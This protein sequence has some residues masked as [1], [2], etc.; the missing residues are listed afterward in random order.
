MTNNQLLVEVRNLQGQ[1]SQAEEKAIKLQR[2]LTRPGLTAIDR[3]I[4]D[5]DLTEAQEE[6]ASLQ[7]QLE[8]KLHEVELL[9]IRAPASGHIVNWQLRQNLLRR[10]VQ[11]GQNLMTL[12]A[13]DTPWQIEL[14]IPERRVAHVLEA[15]R[16]S[17]EPLKV[18][19]T[20]ASHPG[21]EFIG[22]LIELDN[23]LDVRGDEGNAVLARVEFDEQQLSSDL[24]RS[25]TRVTARIHAGQRS[26]GYVWFHE[27]IETART[28]W[29]LWF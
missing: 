18:S 26:M 20:L 1:L 13:P 28:A 24:L 14:E 12:V 15:Q 25:G 6:Q 11:R 21:A 3:G 27:L 9:N 22:R 10:P 4:L 7:R 17:D 2:A 19:F 5:G 16:Q 8:L 23:K 29:L